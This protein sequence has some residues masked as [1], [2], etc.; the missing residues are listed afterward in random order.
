M[1]SNS[2]RLATIDIRDP[3]LPDPDLWLEGGNI[4]IAVYEPKDFRSFDPIR[5]RHLWKVH[6]SHLELHELKSWLAIAPAGTH[7]G[8]D[9]VELLDY[10]PKDVKDFLLH[11]HNL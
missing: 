8:V 7:E 3:D 10:T 2:P 9:V 6:R 4:I 1:E 5:R 11:I